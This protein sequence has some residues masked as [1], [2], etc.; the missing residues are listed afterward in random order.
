MKLVLGHGRAQGGQDAIALKKHWLDALA[1]GL[2]RAGRSM[3]PGTV[4]ELPFYGDRLDQLVAQV[5]AP[6]TLNVS[7]RGTVSDADVTLRGEILHDIALNSGVTDADIARE[8][9]DGPQEKGPQ[10][11]K[12]VLA[13]V[14]ALDRVPDETGNLWI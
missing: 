10:N 12:W 13:T 2:E 8:L 1:Y 11:W 6:L 7:A 14:R 9:G 5:N 3:P 4:V